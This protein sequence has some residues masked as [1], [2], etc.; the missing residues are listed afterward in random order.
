MRKQR[1]TAAGKIT[2]TL[3]NIGIPG[4]IAFKAGHERQK[5]PWPT[6]LQKLILNLVKN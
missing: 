4:G 1:L 3:V 6:E 2:E 5:K